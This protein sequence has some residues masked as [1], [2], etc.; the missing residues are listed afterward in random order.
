MLQLRKNKKY[1]IG[2]AAVIAII[3]IAAVI[4]VAATKSKSMTTAGG[5]KV[6][7]MQLQK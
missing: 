3:A 6:K 7:A 2:L 4:A 1:Q 5:V